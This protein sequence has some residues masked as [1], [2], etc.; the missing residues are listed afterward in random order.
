MDKYFLSVKLHSLTCMHTPISSGRGLA[1]QAKGPA[2]RSGQISGLSGRLA[3]GNPASRNSWGWNFSW[4]TSQNS[5]M[6]WNP[7][8]KSAVYAGTC[9]SRDTYFFTATWFSSARYFTLWCVI[10][11][12]NRRITLVTWLT[13]R[14]QAGAAI[15]QN[16]ILASLQIELLA[17]RSAVMCLRGSRSSYHRPQYLFASS[18]DLAIADSKVTHVTL[19]HWYFIYLFI[20]FVKLCVCVCTC[21]AMTTTTKTFRRSLW[22]AVCFSIR[23]VFFIR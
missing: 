20:Y 10:R 2:D 3:F 13:D 22:R 23:S 7:C 4:R 16:I 6:V 18:I 21:C 9:F 17:L 5:C 8:Q 12:K 11:A 15:Q 19:L 14:G 1:C